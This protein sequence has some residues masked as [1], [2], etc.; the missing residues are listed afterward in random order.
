MNREVL[1]QAAL[2]AREMAYAP[3]SGFHVGAALLLKDGTIYTGGNIENASYG[4]CNCAERTAIFKAVSEG[5]RDF[6]AIVIT[7]GLKGADPVEY[8]YPCGICRQVM[9]EFADDDFVVIVAKSLTDY[10]E[11]KLAEIMPFGFGGESIK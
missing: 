2:D 8:A 3:Y 5:R 1:I 6:E 9:L 11:Y 4:A 10:Q 7:G